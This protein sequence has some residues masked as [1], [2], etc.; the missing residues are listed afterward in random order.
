M[1]GVKEAKSRRTAGTGTGRLLKGKDLGRQL[2]TVRLAAN[3]L[4]NAGA[5]DRL[6]GQPHQEKAVDED[7][8]EVLVV[9]QK[10]QIGVPQRRPPL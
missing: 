3:L 2:K 10:H 6:V 8:A 4:V 7:G 9:I 5:K 1:V